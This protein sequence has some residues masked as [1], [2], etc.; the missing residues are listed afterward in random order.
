M[1]KTIVTV[2][3]DARDCI[4]PVYRDGA[5]RDLAKIVVSLVRLSGAKLA[6][7]READERGRYSHDSLE[8]TARWLISCQPTF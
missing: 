6:G 1:S 8:R 4:E 5:L 2:I 7:V 3:R